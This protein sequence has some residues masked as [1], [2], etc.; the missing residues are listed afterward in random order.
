M[1]TGN[2]FDDAITTFSERYADQNEADF[3]QLCS[4]IESGRVH[5]AE[6]S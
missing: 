5:A 1:G 2:V 3:A 4:A 6:V